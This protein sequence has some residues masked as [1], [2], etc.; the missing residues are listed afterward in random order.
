MASSVRF[1]RF[2]YVLGVMALQVPTTA[3]SARDAVPLQARPA[4][5]AARAVVWTEDVHG[6]GEHSFF[7]DATGHVLEERKGLALYDGSTLLTAERREESIPTSDCG[8]A[9]KA[10]ASSDA[11]PPAAGVGVS[12]ALVLVS[13]AGEELRVLPAPRPDR[14]VQ[15]FQSIVDVTGSAGPYLF[16]RQSTYVLGCGGMGN[17]A[18]ESFVWDVAHHKLTPR[19]AMFPDDPS[20]EGRAQRALSADAEDDERER[21]SRGDQR[22]TELLP[23][24]SRDGDL[25]LSV[26][27]VTPTSYAGTRGGWSS[28]TRSVFVPAKTLPA[29]LGAFAAAPEPVRTFVRA[30]LSPVRGYSI[31]P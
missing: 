24:L 9:V 13:D 22:F 29:A 12:T 11:V 30:Q 15:A 7:L 5:A 4:P 19:S 20:L 28:Y 18:V 10:S 23:A 31:R 21:E 17:L 6:E 1:R 26:R 16:L 3:C 2:A 8:D 14:A 27:F 25:S